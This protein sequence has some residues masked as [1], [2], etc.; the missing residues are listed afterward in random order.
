MVDTYGE[1]LVEM[2]DAL[3]GE[4]SDATIPFVR[5][6]SLFHLTNPA[7]PTPAT[8]KMPSHIVTVHTDEADVCR[9]LLSATC[10][11]SASSLREKIKVSASTLALYRGFSK[12]MLEDLSLHPSVVHQSKSQRK[13]LATKVSFEMMLRNQAYSNLVE[14]VF[15]AHLRLSIHAHV[16]SGPKFGVALLAHSGCRVVDDLLGWANGGEAQLG[17]GAKSDDDLLHIPTPWHNSIAK[18]A[19]RD[20]WVVVKKKAITEA[21]A[22][23]GCVADWVQGDKG[24]GGGYTLLT[25]NPNNKNTPAV[26]VAHPALP[27]PGDGMPDQQQQQQQQQLSLWQYILRGVYRIVGIRV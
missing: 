22:A 12:F 7:I 1:K 27:V 9:Q 24:G 10:T 18:V 15:P 19:G 13:K 4:S 3:F 2:R 26:P 21:V 16:N 6:P 25:M 23:G 8:T 11:P 17:D 5:L 14:M 20:G